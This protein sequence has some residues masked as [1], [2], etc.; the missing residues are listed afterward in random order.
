V[1]GLVEGVVQTNLR[2]SRAN[3][4]APVVTEDVAPNAHVTCASGKRMQPSCAA[5]D[6]EPAR[7]RRLGTLGMWT[8]AREERAPLV[9]A[10]MD[11]LLVE[12]DVSVRET[13]AEDL[14]DAG[15]DVSEAPNADAALSVARALAQ[16]GRPPSVLVTD[17][18]LG[19]GMD[20]LGLAAEV[21][22]RW[23]E[24]GVVAITATPSKLSGR[25]PDAREVCLVKPFG[26]PRLAAAVNELMGR[27]RR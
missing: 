16:M 8:D 11:V 12:D 21:R 1:V 22:R 27:S 26:P 15:L 19:P 23:P 10:G 18:N 6:N 3:A 2:L 9:V 5:T 25:D 13:L 17:V 4:L 24:M 20:G 14:A 7:P